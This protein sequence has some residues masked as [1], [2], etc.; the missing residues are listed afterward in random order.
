MY[1]RTD[2]KTLMALYEK[3]ITDL[4]REIENLPNDSL[5]IHISSGSGHENYPT[6]QKLL[7]KVV[8][9]C[10]QCATIIYTMKG[11]H[12]TL[13]EIHFRTRTEDYTADLREAFL[14]TK[15]LLA[16]SQDEGLEKYA[17]SLKIDTSWGH[18][19][20]QAIEHAIVQV[21]RHKMLVETI[22]LNEFNKKPGS[23]AVK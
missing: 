10:Y 20:Q 3:V 23:L 11:E 22:R 5:T 16:E 15:M 8:A 2:L 18:I 13:P 7:H 21:L 17:A 19:Y 9:K 6:L 1:Q 4:T 14:F 12:G